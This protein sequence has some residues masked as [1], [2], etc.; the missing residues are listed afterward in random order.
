M[1]KTGESVRTLP[2]VAG[3]LLAIAGCTLGPMSPEERQFP[4][5]TAR[6][7]LGQVHA[8]CQQSFLASG[9][10]IGAEDHFGIEGPWVQDQG[11]SWRLS[12][13]FEGS[14]E[15]TRISGSLG[16]RRDQDL[17]PSH[18]LF[19]GA[20]EAAVDDAILEDVNLEA[21]SRDR[22]N[23]EAGDT[24][25]F[26]K[27]ERKIRELEDR[28]ALFWSTFEDQLKSPSQEN[29]LAPVYP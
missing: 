21:A 6:M 13:T 17:R 9:F 16:I 23:L 22:V 27:R 5:L 25:R 4:F 29:G 8:R 3:A 20:A 19:R 28:V 1:P 18:G 12:V 2:V 11:L 10:S 15:I 24:R 14:G 7:D 26:L